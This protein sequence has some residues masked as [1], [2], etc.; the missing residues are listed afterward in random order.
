MHK[1]YVGQRVLCVE[2]PPETWGEWWYRIRHP[3]K[4]A[5]V[6]VGEVYTVSN[7]YTDDTM[8]MIEV[9]E[10][11]APSEDWW[12]AGFRSDTFRPMSERKTDISVLTALLTPQ[13]S[14]STV[15]G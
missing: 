14:K 13:K 7:L 6:K 3:S 1:F 15:E 10:V 5:D 11:Y 12:L 4:Y 9:A 8:L 2:T